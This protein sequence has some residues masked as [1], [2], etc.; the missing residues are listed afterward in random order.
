MCDIPV[1]YAT[2]EGQTR[3]I[4]ER[5]AARLRELGFFSE[6][7]C[8]TSDQATHLNWTHVRGVVVGASL[9]NGKHQR[10]AT[11]FVVAHRDRLNAGY[12]AFYSVS[13]AAA[14]RKPEEVA[15]ARRLAVSFAEEVGW[16]PDRVM[17][18]A[19]RLAYRTYGFFTRLLMRAIAKREGGSTDTSR[20][21][22]YTDWPE[23]TRFADEVARGVL[24][25]EVV[26]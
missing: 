11:A 23:V 13:L 24:K 19:G 16:Q 7:I 4:A 5:V 15:A 3:R 26:A 2:T 21:H 9:H 17:C 20:D 18:F 6:A 22:E 14:S 8:V 1:L 12:S 10:S 25:K